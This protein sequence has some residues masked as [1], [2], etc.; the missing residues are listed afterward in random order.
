MA[1]V[2][3]DCGGTNLAFARYVSGRLT[4]SGAIPTPEGAADLPE[5]ILAA[6]T[7]RL[8]DALAVGIGVAGLV[9]SRAGTLVWMP[10]TRGE[11]VAVA[12][13]IAGR[14]GLPVVVDNDANLAGLAEARAG[15]GRGHRMVLT[16]TLGTGIG[17]GLTIGGEIERG[18]GF[19]G[20]VGHLTVEPGGAPCPCGGAG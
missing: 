20:E 8:G 1:V 13:P 16:L 3:V 17:G 5:A 6:V 7:P 11:R 10:H 4:E 14:L 2:A 9:D 19:L 15:A 18:R 12:G